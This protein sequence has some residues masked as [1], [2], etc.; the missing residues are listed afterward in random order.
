MGLSRQA[1]VFHRYGNYNYT[2]PNINIGD[3]SINE[4]VQ[5][6]MYSECLISQA[7]FF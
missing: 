5:T 4:G 3:M 6:L 1:I 7:V 2:E